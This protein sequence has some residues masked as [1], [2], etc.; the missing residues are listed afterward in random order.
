M[1]SEKQLSVCG[2]VCVCKHCH[3]NEM[4]L[5]ILPNSMY[6]FKKTTCES[7][8]LYEYL[9]HRYCKIMKA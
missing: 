6:Y 5:Q 4:R 7:L 2:G 3:Y 8:V 1:N 9:S